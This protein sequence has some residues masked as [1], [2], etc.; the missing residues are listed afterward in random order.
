M[1]P[2]SR[3]RRTGQVINQVLLG[4]CY[5]GRRPHHLP[6]LRQ[7]RSFM[8]KDSA[9]RNP[10]ARPFHERA[11]TDTSGTLTHNYKRRDTTTLFA[12][13]DVLKYLLS[14]LIPAAHSPGT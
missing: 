2:R 13:L 6:V 7:M 12:A 14:I 9:R 8:G 11:S 10:K 4:Q 1:Q 5:W 3:P